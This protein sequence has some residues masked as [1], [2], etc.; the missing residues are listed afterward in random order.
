MSDSVPFGK[1][2]RLKYFDFDP[3]YVPLNHGSF[4][5]APIA[6]NARR[7]AE[8]KEL[9]ANPDKYFR[10]TAGSRTATVLKKLWP[11]LGITSEKT[12]KNVVFVTNATM[13]VNTVL[14]SYPFKKNDVIIRANTTY[15]ACSK[16]IDF[17]G[18]IMG[19]KSKTVNIEYPVKPSTVVESYAFAIDEAITEVA[20][21]NKNTDNSG[22]IVVLFDT[23]SSQPGC[24]L[25]WKELVQ[26]CKEKNVISI[27]DGAHGVGLLTDLDL[28]NVRP[29]FFI[30]N[31]HKWFFVPAPAALLYVDEK[32]HPI[33][34]TIP[35]SHSYVSPTNASKMTGLMRENLLL[36]KFVFVGTSDYTGY[37]ASEAAIEFREKICGG[38]ENIRGY[39]YN[40]AKEAAKLF[41]TDLGT[42]I[43][44]SGDK[45]MDDDI[46]T[47]MVNVY[48]PSPSGPKDIN[49]IVKSGE[50]IPVDLDFA[51]NELQYAIMENSNVYFPIGIM[52]GKLYTRLSAQVYLDLDDFK[53]GLEAFKKE[54]KEFQEKWGNK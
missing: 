34:Q 38:E 41:S 28:E 42:E 21:S 53:Y 32:Y 20:E 27:V 40:L 10:F 36:D 8:N 46:S 5:S 48:L 22:N 14:R 26:L 23:V 31:L 44:A 7:D 33:I 54:F 16:T 52:E 1:Q 11:Y 43:V 3:E 13:G 19:V 15:Q 4:G 50:E 29:D 39:S 17:L 51:A 35:V 45:N 47:A 6:V 49:A 9:R 37:I 12:G 25:P 18:D 24:K 2:F 30:T